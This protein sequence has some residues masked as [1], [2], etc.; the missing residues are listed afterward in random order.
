M[1]TFAVSA[2]LAFCLTFVSDL[3]A[4]EFASLEEA[5]K[6]SIKAAALIEEIGIVK[7]REQFHD[8]DGEFLKKDLYVFAYDNK[9]TVLAFGSRPHLT[10]KVLIN[11]RDMQ[12]RY[13]VQEMLA[14][15][16]GEKQ[17]LDYKMPNSIT[18]EFEYKSSFVVRT[19]DYFVGVGA[20]SSK[21]AHASHREH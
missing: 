16:P 9:G 15:P 18:N 12:G 17:W 2:F 19:K 11:F 8:P 1:K 21:E 13:L 4:T 5:R 3:A 20:R 6:L 14:I 7:A 10:G